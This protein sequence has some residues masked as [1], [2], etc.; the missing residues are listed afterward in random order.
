MD[1]NRQGGIN[2]LEVEHLS[3]TYYTPLGT[4]RVVR[5]VSF[6]IQRGEVLALVGETGCG[7]SISAFA[8]VGYLLP[9]QPGEARVNGT[10]LFEGKDLISLSTSEFRKLRGN[11][12]AMVYQNPGTSLNPTMKVGLQI[13]ELLQEHIGLTSKQA[14]QRAEELFVSVGLAEPTILG[15]R[16]P[17]QLSGGMQQRVMIAMAIACEPDLLILDE[18]TTALDVTTEANILDLI[19][20]L[21]QRVNAGILFVSHNLAT[22]ARVADR[23]AVMYAGQTIEKASTSEIFKKPK[24]PYTIGLLQCIPQSPFQS[25]NI[26]RLRSIPG[27]TYAPEEKNIKACL[28]AP[29]CPIARESCRRES[30]EM[31]DAGENH[32]S[33]C[34]FWNEVYNRIWGELV[35]RDAEMRENTEVILEARNLQRYFGNWQ[36][37]YLLFGQRVQPPVRAVA[38]IDFDVKTERTLG[39]VGESG[40]GKTTLA[41]LV[42][43]LIPRQQ[44]EILLRDEILAPQIEDRT[45]NQRAALRMVFQ[46]P[47]TSLNP[48][49]PVRYA[50]ERSLKKFAQLSKNDFRESIETL[51]RAVRLEPAYLERRPDALSGGEQQRIVL[52]ATFAGK[53]D[54][55]IADEAVASLDVSVQ[56]QVLNLLQDHQTAHGTAYIFI[57]HDISVIRYISD[58]ILVLYAGFLAESGPTECVLQIPS[59]PYTEALLS[60]V[61]IPDP[62]A[63]P[64]RIRLSGVVPT[65]RESVQGCVF[66]GRC[67]RKIGSICDNIPP[68]AQIGLNS[69]NHF[70]H[71]H[72]PVEK[73]VILQ[74]DRESGAI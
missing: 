2:L 69:P 17:H 32:Q 7:K 16:Y 23:V 42:V 60:A 37:K 68:P 58:D 14:R 12:I 30:P 44:G 57:S 59:H 3:V 62:D 25:G 51:A 66:A 55:I 67:P 73:L 63:I 27:D 11:R 54:L 56:A 65:L 29:R 9:F 13:E 38:N 6:T 26:N 36:R 47:T 24:H 72:I 71:C 40:C 52:A 19:V 31:L 35:S 1:E 5:D 22:V 49:L 64:T 4:F 8:I 15:K 50:I 74:Q 46:N 21:K 20:D 10:I 18:P 45:Y 33:R 61:P 53:A 41:R 28:F 43:G 48:K 70:I 34:F 39:I